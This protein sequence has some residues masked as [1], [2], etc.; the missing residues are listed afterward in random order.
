MLLALQHIEPSFAST[1][2]PPSLWAAGLVTI[3]FTI[4]ARWLRGVTF[5]GAIAG[6]LICFALYAG[7]GSAAFLVL[8]TVF[9]LTWLATRLG[10]RNKQRQGTAEKA[11]GRNASQVLANL[12]V[13]GA[14]G[15]LLPAVG[16]GI[17]LLA[18][19][20]ALAEAAADTVSSE[21]GQSVSRQ[22]RLVTTGEQVPAGTDGGITLAGTVCGI[23]SA[24]I[25][26]SVAAVL[27]LVTP[28]GATA[29]ALAATAG[30]F[31]DSLMGALL[32]SRGLL[33]NNGVNF[34]STVFAAAIAMLLGWLIPAFR[35]VM[36]LGSLPIR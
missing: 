19:V 15:A 8:V 12:F 35:P 16:N 4:L 22:A 29:C 32:E 23:L 3:A 17:L 7:V 27:Q 33:K 31:A 18:L 14:S 11:D 6:A 9:V 5:S 10:Y 25:A 34:L 21:I 1:G 30:M 36:Y 26:C 20:A 24:G 28:S 13:A 2:S